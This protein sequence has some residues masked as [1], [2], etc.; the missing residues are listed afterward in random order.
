MSHF[1][2]RIIFYTFTVLFVVLSIYFSLLVSGYSLTWSDL[3][4]SHKFNLLQKTGILAVNSTPRGA[5]IDLERN[6]KS[7]FSSRDVI[8]DKK[9]KTPYKIKNLAP[10]EYNL[11]MELEG[12]WPFEKKVY[13]HPGQ[14]NYIEEVVLLK[15]TL[16]AM[17]FSSPIQEIDLNNSFSHLIFSEEKK[18]FNIANESE[19]LFDE[20]ISDLEFLSNDLVLANKKKI[21]NYK[22]DRYLDLNL[23]NLE[24]FHNLKVNKNNLYYLSSGSLFSYNLSSQT[25]TLILSDAGLIDYCFS[26]GNIFLISQTNNLWQFKVYSIKDK[27]ITKS[28]D[29]PFGQYEFLPSKNNFVFVYD[30]LYSSLY[31]INPYS[32]FN[33]LVSVLHNVKDVNFISNDSFLYFS[34]FEIRIFNLSLMQS[35]LLARFENEIKSLVWDSRAYLIFSDGQSIKAIDFKYDNYITNL[36][37]FDDLSTL[38]LDEKSGSL[39]FTGRIGNR[40]GLY[41]LFIQ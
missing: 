6:F 34:G 1:T 28:L 33:P 17:I 10:G 35:S 12:Y 13:I 9:V 32:Q 38:K 22:E 20:K 19:L 24:N 18:L 40:E 11:K 37:T 8:K 2:R 31:L 29:L 30:K 25:N 16:P 23:E 15:K 21:F 4:G 39:F 27:K 41:K 7:L 5:K 3:K 36:F 26:V 14:T